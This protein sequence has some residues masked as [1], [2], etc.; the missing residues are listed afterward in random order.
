LS[1][2]VD[3]GWGEKRGG[4]GESRS[5]GERSDWGERWGCVG[6]CVLLGR[7]YRRGKTAK[8]PP[9]HPA[10]ITMRAFGIAAAVMGVCVLACAEAKRAGAGG[11]AKFARALGDPD[12][13]RNMTA[14]VQA[15]GYTISEHVVVTAD[16]FEL[17]VFHMPPTR[18]NSSTSPAPVVLLQ[19]GLEDSSWT[20]VCNFQTESLAFILVDRGLYVEVWV[21]VVLRGKRGVLMRSCPCSTRPAPYK[22]VCWCA[23]RSRGV[24]F[25]IH[26]CILNSIHPA[27]AVTCGSGTLVGTRT[28]RRT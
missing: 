27:L 19:H 2:E 6:P 3:G 17:G 14:I 11:S 20:W 22:R 23:R 28:L 24:P 10:L 16:G 12:E 13:G 4:V 7:C 8:N 1:G 9:L 25:T 26:P 5:R 21:F 18:R 15:R